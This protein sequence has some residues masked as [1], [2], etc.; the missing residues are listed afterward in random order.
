MENIKKLIVYRENTSNKIK[1]IAGYVYILS[2][3][4]I[5]LSN[6]YPAFNKYLFFLVYDKFSSS[7]ILYVFLNDFMKFSAYYMWI[8]PLLLYIYVLYYLWK[9]HESILYFVSIP[10]ISFILSRILQRFFF[11]TRPYIEYHIL[12]LIH[13]SADNGFPSDHALLVFSILFSSFY[14]LKIELRERIKYAT[15][16][17]YFFIFF[18][19]IIPISRVYVG[20]HHWTDIFGSLLIVSLS[21]IIYISFA[22]FYHSK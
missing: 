7:G 12:P 11:D 3:I 4:I 1:M 13:V 17:I 15:A 9:I 16:V 5:L 8:I 10:F 19:I 22:F 18:S 21:Y 20:A 14:I 6:T 2:L